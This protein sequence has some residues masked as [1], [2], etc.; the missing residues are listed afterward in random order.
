MKTSLTRTLAA[1]AA[2]VALPAAVAVAPASAA[3]KDGSSTRSTGGNAFV[4]WTEHDLGDQL[5]LPGNTHVGYLSYYAMTDFSDVYGQI[6]DWQCDPGEVPGGGHG[7]P[8]EGGPF[9]DLVQTRNLAGGEGL[10]YAF[11]AR[12]GTATLKGQLLVLNG[13]HGEGDGTVLARPPA[14]ITWKADG[15]RYTFRRSESWS[16]RMG[17]FRSAVRGSG[18]P[19]AVSGSIGAMGFT[20]DKDDTSFGNVES[21]TERFRSRG[22]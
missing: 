19:A 14:N 22:R 15:P 7:G 5:R 1:V 16:S 9:C 12:T 6:Q 3:P 13:G 2:L 21:W 11:D 18:F 20:D 10:T 4:E 8:D 17:S